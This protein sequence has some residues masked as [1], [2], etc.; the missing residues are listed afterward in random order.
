MEE[1]KTVAA[2]EEEL[3]HRDKSFLIA[4]P[5]K[6]GLARLRRQ[7]QNHQFSNGVLLCKYWASD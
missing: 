4:L 1:T 2:E 3:E 6:F 7:A 5:G